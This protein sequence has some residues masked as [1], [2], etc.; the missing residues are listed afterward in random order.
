MA[1]A[2]SK[3]TNPILP[4]H[5]FLEGPDNV[6]ATNLDRKSQDAGISPIQRSLCFSIEPTV[7]IYGEFGMR[8]EDVAYITPHGPKFFTNQSPSIDKP[9]G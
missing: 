3:V 5:L 6:N 8:L 1:D 2:A 7:V 4:V 9:F